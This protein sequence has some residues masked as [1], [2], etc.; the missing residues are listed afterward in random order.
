MA[1]PAYCPTSRKA[2]TDGSLGFTSQPTQATGEFQASERLF[3]KLEL[4]GNLGMT[5]FD[6][7][8]QTDTYIHFPPR[9][10]TTHTHI[11]M[12]TYAYACKK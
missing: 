6:C 1:V 4:S 7:H 5:T 12:H 11:T 9:V 10:H 3:P 2:E 8:M